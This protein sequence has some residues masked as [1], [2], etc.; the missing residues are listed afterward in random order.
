MANKAPA[1]ISPETL[2]SG[3]IEKRAA[4]LNR[5]KALL[6]E[7]RDHFRSYIDILDKQKNVIENGKTEDILA[8]VEMEESVAAG[9]ASVQKALDPMR[10]LYENVC[11]GAKD[12]SISEISST[13]ENLQQETFQR[14][15]HNKDLLQQRMILI[16]NELKNLR[17]N[18]FA[19]RKSIYAEN[20][21]ATLFDISG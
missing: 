8:Q 12:N 3:E 15:K 5:F 11:S 7:Q 4:V 21:G 10:F 16:Q 2:S 14:V 6:I 13:L 17:S 9:I 1:D 18:P 19:K 20:Q